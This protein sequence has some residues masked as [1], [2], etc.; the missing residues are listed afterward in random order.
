MKKGALSIIICILLL[1][2]CGSSKPVTSTSISKEISVPTALPTEVIAAAPENTATATP[3]PEV[4]AT[5]MQTPNPT[6]KP[7]KSAAAS[8][9]KKETEN[10]PKP[11]KKSGDT[12]YV[13][14]TGKKY[15]D[16]DCSTLKGKGSAM[17]FEEAVGEGR[18]PCKIC[19]K[20]TE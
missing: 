7:E 18:E 5:P 17:S 8:S 12:V 15:H 6:E 19:Q 20:T 11:V 2:G 1:C 9:A 13:G 4:T 10:N 14:K 16:E 3:T